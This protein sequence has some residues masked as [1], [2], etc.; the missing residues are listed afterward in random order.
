[1][2]NILTSKIKNIEFKSPVIAASG[3]FGY[4]DEAKKFVNLNE[5]GCII[6]KSITLDRRLGSPPSRIH[7]SDAG[8][9]NSIGLA[10]IGVQDFCDK[11]ISTLNSIGTNFIVS[12]AGSTFEE[13]IEVINR[14]EKTNG[15]HVGYEVNVSCPNVKEGGMEF[16]VDEEA[17]FKLTKSLRSVTDKI[18]IIKLSPNVT[19][20]ED[21][22]LSAES[23]GADAISAVNTFVGLGIDYKTGKMLLSTK[24]GGVSGPP[25]KPMAL[26]KVHKIYNKVKIPVIGMGGISSFKDVIEFIRIG[27]S[28]VQVGTLNYRSPSIISTFNADL[29]R[30]LSDNNISHINQ[31]IGRFGDA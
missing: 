3:T 8:M 16:G 26:A 22:A 18:L 7:G 20:I 25:I 17:T 12:V 27:S 9:L 6:T 10:N 21:I 30:F 24:F 5:I 11:K 31:L 23:A 1:M 2:K 4:G 29:K 14:I 19:N 28:M 13:Y 15:S